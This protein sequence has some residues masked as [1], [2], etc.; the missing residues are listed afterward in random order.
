MTTVPLVEKNSSTILRVATSITSA[1]TSLAVVEPCRPRPLVLGL[2]GPSG[3]R[4]DLGELELKSAREQHLG[5]PASEVAVHDPGFAHGV[6]DLLVRV[7]LGGRVRMTAKVEQ[8]EVTFLGE[9]HAAWAQRRDD[10]SQRV[11]RVR[12]VHQQSPTMDKIEFWLDFQFA[13]VQ[14]TH[15]DVVGQAS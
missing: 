15:I 1:A 9:K 11:S 5:E 4:V 2:T 6:Q 13:D 14:L 7:V 8:S 12:Q 3:R 10:P